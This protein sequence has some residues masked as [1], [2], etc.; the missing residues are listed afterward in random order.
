MYVKGVH[1]PEFFRGDRPSSNDGRHAT[2]EGAAFRE[3]QH[4]RALRGG[5]STVKHTIFIF[6]G[7]RLLVTHHGEYGLTEVVGLLGGDDRR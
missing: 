4:G 7:K 2:D 3:P 5:M 6:E 1:T